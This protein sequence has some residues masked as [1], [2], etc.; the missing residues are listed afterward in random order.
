[1]EDLKREA[2][3]EYDRWRTDPSF[4]VPG[5]ESV[6]DVRRRIERFFEERAAQLGADES[7]LLVGHG[8]LNRMVLS[9]IM[10]LD[11]QSSR[12][13]GQDNTAINVFEFR[14][15]KATCT[16]WNAR[17]H[18][19]GDAPLLPVYAAGAIVGGEI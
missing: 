7:V 17:P 11:P 8:I 5:G 2:R 3:A 14:N 15:G 19:G 10:G 1:V 6:L 16:A 12:Y 4:A 9:V 18:L 13:F